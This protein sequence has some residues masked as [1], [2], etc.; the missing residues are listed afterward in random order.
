MVYSFE[1][2]V[3]ELRAPLNSFKGVDREKLISDWL[4]HK[5]EH[6][7]YAISS[8]ARRCWNYELLTVSYGKMEVCKLAFG[9]LYGLKSIMR[10]EEKETATCRLHLGKTFQSSH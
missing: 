8:S 4:Q 1:K 2:F 3:T 5:F 6:S 10:K 9:A 7:G